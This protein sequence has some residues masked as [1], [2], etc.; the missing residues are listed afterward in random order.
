MGLSN[1]RCCRILWTWSDNSSAADCGSGH[2]N[3]GMFPYFPCHIFLLV[4]VARVEGPGCSQT[5]QGSLILLEKLSFKQFS[6]GTQLFTWFSDSLHFHFT[7]CSL[8]PGR[9]FKQLLQILFAPCL[10]NHLLSRASLSLCF[11]F[12]TCWNEVYNVKNRVSFISSPQ[13]QVFLS[14]GW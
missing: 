5:L 9:L 2:P 8:F 13:I 7:C 1:W 4:S 10:G 12:F 3:S 6:L 14:G 11:W